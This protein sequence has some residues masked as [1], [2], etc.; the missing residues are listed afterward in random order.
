MF[1]AKAKYM[2][3]VIVFPNWLNLCTFV[4]VIQYIYVK[5]KYHIQVKLQLGFLTHTP[6]IK[7]RVICGFTVTYLRTMH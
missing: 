4:I 2:Q 7:T 5:N 6:Q 3:N 1:Y